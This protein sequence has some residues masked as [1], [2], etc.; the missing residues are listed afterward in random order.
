M[1]SKRRQIQV[2]WLEGRLLW[3]RERVNGRTGKVLAFQKIAAMRGGGES[4]HSIQQDA[5]SH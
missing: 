1:L 5:S 2:H 3:T 4:A